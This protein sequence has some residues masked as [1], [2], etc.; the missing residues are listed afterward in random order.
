MITIPGRFLF[1]KVG[2]HANETWDQILERKRKE[3]D[4]TGQIF[5]GYGGTTC[6][7]INV[8]QPFAR[9]SI[10]EQGGILLV[11]DYVDSRAD[12]DIVPAREYS[13]DGVNWLPIPKGITVTGSRYAL[14]L[15]EI[16]PG[17][18]TIQLNEFE[19]AIGLEFPTKS[20]HGVNDFSV[21]RAAPSRPLW[22]C[23]LGVGR[24]Y[25]GS[26]C[27]PTAQPHLLG[28]LGGGGTQRTITS[29]QADSRLPKHSFGLPRHVTEGTHCGTSGVV[30]SKFTG[31]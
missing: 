19:V 24:G 20:G 13:Q 6:H 9:L 12:P 26:L 30:F 31:D 14:V 4:H 16:K 15:D 28:R 17:D 11:M 10:K 18:L 29:R 21:S 2:N 8:V 25:R 27:S 5:W 7:P 23:R 3:F 1:M 22:S